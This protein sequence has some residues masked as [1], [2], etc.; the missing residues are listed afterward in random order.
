MDDLSRF[1]CQNAVC[2]AYGKRGGG[3]L[4]VCM[5]YGK[6]KRLRLL[7]CRTCHARFSERKGTPLFQARLPAAQVEAVLAHIAEGC[8]VRKT[9]RLVGVNRETVARYSGL[10]GAH[11]QALHQELV[12]FS[13]ADARGAV[14]RKVGLRGQERKAL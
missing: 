5:R 6:D 11:A 2:A 12:A 7:Y 8:G 10:A 14:R 9:G 3:N 13:P 4:T 1:C